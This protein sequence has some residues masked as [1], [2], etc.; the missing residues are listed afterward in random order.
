[1]NNMGKAAEE[2]TG[3]ERWGWDI[4][5]CGNLFNTLKVDMPVD[6]IK[7]C[8]QCNVHRQLKRLKLSLANCCETDMSLHA[9]T[10]SMRDLTSNS[11]QQRGCPGRH[12]TEFSRRFRE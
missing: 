9:S 12:I 7:F 1:M 6:N 2:A 11:P 5:S 3:K 8:S 4:K 10:S